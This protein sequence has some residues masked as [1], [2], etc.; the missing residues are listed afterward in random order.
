[1]K[2]KTSELLDGEY[3]CSQTI[4][5]EGFS[6][7]FTGKEKN[8][9]RSSTNKNRIGAFHLERKESKPKA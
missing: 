2:I 3:S 5:L 1:M 7:K 6:W 8:G 4:L 9:W